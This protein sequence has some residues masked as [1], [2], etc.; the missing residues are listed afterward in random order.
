MDDKVPRRRH[1][2]LPPPAPPKLIFDFDKASTKMAATRAFVLLSLL[3]SSYVSG[4]AREDVPT[5]REESRGFAELLSACLMWPVI[6][7][8]QAPTVNNV[9]ER[10]MDAGA[11]ASVSVKDGLG[12]S[13][14]FLLSF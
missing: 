10:S 12:M 11:V 14:S 9:Q 2:A 7:V 5:L 4:L 8:D 1:H 3:A 13:P 6:D